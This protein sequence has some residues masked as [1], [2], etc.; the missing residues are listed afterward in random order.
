MYKV[1]FDIEV[2][3]VDRRDRADPVR[4]FMAFFRLYIC[5]PERVDGDPVLEKTSDPGKVVLFAL[6]NAG[7]NC[8]VH[9]ENAGFFLPR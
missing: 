7:M 3:F 2:E 4:G 6:L 5:P 8:I 9:E 1:E